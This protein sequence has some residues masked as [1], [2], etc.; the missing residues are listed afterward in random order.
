MTDSHTP[1]P[2]TWTVD[3]ELEAYDR[4]LMDRLGLTR[5]EIDESDEGT[6]PL[7]TLSQIATLGG[8]ARNTPGAARQRTLRGLAKVAFPDPD[9]AMLRRMPDKPL[10]PSYKVLDY[11][12]ATGNWPLGQAARLA[13]RHPRPTPKA[14]A[15]AAADKITFTTLEE[16]DPELAAQV[17]AKGLN[18]G[19][20]R[21]PE[22]WRH[23]VR[24]SLRRAAA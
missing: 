19:A 4:A 21:S 10:F 9:E 11:F 1:A 17:R 22:Q 13:Q 5:Q 8:L 6:G 15:A 2:P 16:V 23:R 24:T 3:E 18:D 20:R 12:I 7:I 14:P